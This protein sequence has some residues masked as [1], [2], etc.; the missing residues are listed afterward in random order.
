MGF[1]SRRLT[2]SNPS[3][4]DRLYF[5]CVGTVDHTVMIKRR[6]AITRGK[7]VKFLQ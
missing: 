1:M 5:Q 3:G 4:L 7:G 6:E 2:T